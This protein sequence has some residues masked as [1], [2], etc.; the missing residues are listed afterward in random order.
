MV[1]AGI[2]GGAW[3]ELRAGS[4]QCQAPINNRSKT[5]ITDRVQ[6]HRF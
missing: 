6:V 4:Y 5:G 2:R 1:D 3:T